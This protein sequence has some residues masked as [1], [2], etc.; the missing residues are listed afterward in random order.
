MC[1]TDCTNSWKTSNHCGTPRPD[2]QGLEKR[3]PLCFLRGNIVNLLQ[4][5][6]QPRCRVRQVWLHRFLGHE[7]LE[8]CGRLETLSL[9][10]PGGSEPWLMEEVWVRDQI[11]HPSVTPTE[12]VWRIWDDNEMMGW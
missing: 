4:L 5:G 6:T 11:L 10:W 9:M 8:R 12:M 2:P 1:R 3:R 7:S